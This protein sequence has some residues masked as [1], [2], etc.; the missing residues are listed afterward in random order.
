MKLS[1]SEWMASWCVSRIKHYHVCHGR[2][3]LSLA[4]HS[5][6]SASVLTEQEDWYP[7]APSMM[8]GWRRKAAGQTPSLNTALPL[9]EQTAEGNGSWLISEVNERLWNLE[10]RSPSSTTVY[11]TLPHPTIQITKY[12]CGNWW[13]CEIFLQGSERLPPNS[14]GTKGLPVTTQQ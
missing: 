7:A 6:A 13:C 11:Q 3:L 10:G 14:K 2:A 1:H 12:Y 8:R 9:H 4:H 5:C